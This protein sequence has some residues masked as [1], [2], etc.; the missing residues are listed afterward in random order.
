MKKPDKNDIILMAVI[1]AAAV[2]IMLFLFAFR[3]RGV[4]AYVYV[5]GKLFGEYP[6]NKDCEIQVTGY[7][8]GTNILV[9]KDNTARIKEASCP[10]KLCMHQGKISINGQSLICLPNRVVVEIKGWGGDGYDAVTR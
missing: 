3:E 1:T 8:G 4:Y 6:L 9:I 7:D 2:L 10:D 5:D